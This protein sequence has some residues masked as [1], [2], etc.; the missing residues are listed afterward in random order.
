MLPDTF[1]ITTVPECLSTQRFGLIDKISTQVGDFYDRVIH[2]ACDRNFVRMFRPYRIRIGINIG[3]VASALRC[4][5]FIGNQTFIRSNK[6]FASLSVY[7]MEYIL[8]D[9]KDCWMY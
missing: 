5:S 6:D 1:L 7:F 4:F 8:S 9:R 3:I 2:Q